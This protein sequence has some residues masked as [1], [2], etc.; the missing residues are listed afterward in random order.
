[1]KG[2]TPCPTCGHR[3]SDKER[4]EAEYL[5]AEK[6]AQEWLDDLLSQACRIWHTEP[7]EVVGTEHTRSGSPRK[8]ITLTRWTVMWVLREA[9]LSSKAIGRCLGMDHTSVLHALR[10]METMPDL[11]AVAEP[12]VQAYATTNNVRRIA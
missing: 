11:L 3:T 8:A 9:D 4:R 7:D 2:A 12:L 5:A 10:R 6:R 1:M